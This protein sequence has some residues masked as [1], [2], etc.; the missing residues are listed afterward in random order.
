VTRCGAWVG[1][2][3]AKKW[4][5]ITGVSPDTARN[6]IQELIDHGI[7]RQAGGTTKNVVYELVEQV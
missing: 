5:Q 2:L 1:N 3:T 7:L 4:A 6:D